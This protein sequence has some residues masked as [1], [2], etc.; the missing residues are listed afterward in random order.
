MDCK[1]SEWVCV[2]EGGQNPRVPKDA[3]IAERNLKH[4]I[5]VRNLMRN[6]GCC[7]VVPALV[8]DDIPRVGQS[9]TQADMT[10][11]WGKAGGGQIS[12]FGD[13]KM[14]G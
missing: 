4:L 10:A 14:I 13:S 9:H 6:L 5:E 2:T 7:I 1:V 12:Y 8:M 11:G 3:K